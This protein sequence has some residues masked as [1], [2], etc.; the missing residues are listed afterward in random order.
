MVSEMR[1]WKRW[2]IGLLALL[3]LAVL[4]ACAPAPAQAET[5]GRCLSN[6][7]GR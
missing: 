5:S 1:N 6:R 7:R 2:G 3:V 4:A